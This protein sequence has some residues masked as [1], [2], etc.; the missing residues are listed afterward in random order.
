MVFQPKLQL[1]LL[2]V[3]ALMVLMLAVPRLIASLWELRPIAYLDSS[4][5]NSGLTEQQLRII[6]PELQQALDAIATAH[7]FENLAIVNLRLAQFSDKVEVPRHA[8]LAEAENAVQSGVAQACANPYAWLNL[9]L[10]EKRLGKDPKTVTDALMMSLLTGR[11]EEGLYMERLNLAFEYYPSLNT[12]TAPLINQQLRLAW[13]SK[14][15]DVLKLVMQYKMQ[16]V[17][18]A[19]LAYASG[20]Q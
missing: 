18:S 1:V 3:A 17:L 14:R 19:A 5:T 7:N 9:A 15:N 12:D 4:P 10:L 16:K 8:L 11:A 20:G 6:K 13:K 2:F